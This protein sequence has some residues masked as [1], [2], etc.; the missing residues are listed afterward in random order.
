[1][2]RPTINNIG[3]QKM[4][5]NISTIAKETSLEKYFITATIE[6]P[7]T[8]S[9]NKKS[10]PRK[11]ESL[12]SMDCLLKTLPYTFERGYTSKSPAVKL[13]FFFIN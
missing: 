12:E 2:R 6:V 13:I 10:A 1:M 5:L 8:I 11:Y 3:K 4:Y 7:T 9:R